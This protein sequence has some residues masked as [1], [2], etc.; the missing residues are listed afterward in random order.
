MKK[1]KTSLYKIILFFLLGIILLLSG[2]IAG[3]ITNEKENKK[4]LSQYK[5]TLIALEKKINKL[6]KEIKIPKINNSE[7]LD[8]LQA[9]QYKKIKNITTHKKI[10]TNKPK[11]VIIIDD[12]AFKN[13]VKMIKSI[14]YKITPSFFPP[15]KRHPNTIY[16][17]KTFKDYMVH[18]P[19][20]ATHFSHPEPN[21][22]LITDNYTT[23]KKR[24]DEIKKYFPRVKFINN[25]TGSKFTS[26][27]KA[28][29]YLF[30]AL[31]K[32]NLGFVDSM[33]TP[34][35]KSKTIEKIYNIPL[36][37]RNVFL[38]NE[39]NPAYIRKQ[40]KEAIKIAQKRGYAIAIGHPHKIT[41]QTI[42][43]SKDILNKV[44]VI[45]INELAKYAKNQNR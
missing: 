30:K 5:N 10:K 13:E 3:Y 42:K 11:L 23:I 35:S 32:D 8:Y 16:Y 6:E 15:T 28:M 24:I 45:T 39:Q 4:Q 36:F 20:Q 9:T 43:N 33:T 41:L 1:K 21:T 2:F 25:H 19:M 26:N 31:K 17:A 37:R 12:V 44:D 18:L 34:H 22:L 7:I 40:L 14:P 38:D 29:S 27:S